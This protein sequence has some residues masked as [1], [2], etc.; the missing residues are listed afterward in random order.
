MKYEHLE[1]TKYWEAKAKAEVVT[2]RKER[3]RDAI[4]SF[5]F[6]L[7]FLIATL[8]LGY[9]IQH[10]LFTELSGERILDEAE[11]IIQAWLG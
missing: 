3:D 4:R 11:R 7:A 2:L 8:G 6:F 9:A 5:L 1:S 10:G